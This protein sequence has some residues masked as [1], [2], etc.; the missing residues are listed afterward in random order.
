MLAGCLTSSIVNPKK[1]PG[2]PYATERLATIEAN[3]TTF[4]SDIREIKDNV[5][6]LL[7]RSAEQRGAMKFARILY[8]VL[9][10]IAGAVAGFAS[11]LFNMGGSK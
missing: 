11:H 10:V 9:T 8:G 5:T 2:L 1:F 3:Q 7:E 4:D 6:I